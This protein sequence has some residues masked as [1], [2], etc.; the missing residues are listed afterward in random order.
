MMPVE[1]S[2][3]DL[4]QALKSTLRAACEDL[5]PQAVAAI[6]VEVLREFSGVHCIHCG[7]PLSPPAE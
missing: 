4:A 3:E 6:A 1:S 5:E 2:E 7:Q